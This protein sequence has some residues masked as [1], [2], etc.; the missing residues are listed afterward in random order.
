MLLKY[1]YN[2]A[3]AQASYLIGCQACAEAI[4]IDPGRDIAPYLEMAEREGLHIAHVTETHIH[5]DFVSGAR[6]LAAASGAQ[7]YLSAEGGA[8]WQ[9][10]YADANTILL[11]D[12]DIISVGRVLIQAIHTPGH[13]PEHLIFSWT[14]TAGADQP[15]GLIT[16]DCLFVGD[17]GRPDLL[18]TAAGIMGTKEVG[19]RDQF[20]NIQK[21][22]AMPDY[23]QILPGHGAGSACG[24]ALGAIPSSTLGYEKLFNPAFQFTDEDAFV[25]WLLDGQLETPH[26]FARMKRM[27]KQGPA[28][29]ETLPAPERVEGFVVAQAAHHGWVIDARPAEQ[30]AAGHL[31]GA[32][33]IP[34]GSGF[35]GY[36]GW[37]IPDDQPV[38]LITDE[39]AV[40]E[41][42]TALRSVGVDH[43][44]G[45]CAP[46]DIGDDL[47]MVAQT[48]PREAKRLLDDDSAL[49]LDVRGASERH[50][51]QIAGSRHLHY[52]YLMAHVS[53]LPRDT[54]IIVQCAGGTRSM[55]AAS[56]LQ[57]AG[58]RQVVNLRGGID[59]W[60]N[61][62]L[63]VQTG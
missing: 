26:Y 10:A 3:L 32:L 54:P 60:Q 4:V 31:P 11:R 22:R 5:A 39:D 55:I 33:H 7:L 43:V 17:V 42:V 27:N 48:D 37:L 18:E 62:G 16:G 46:S 25:A 41:L 24:K 34:P 59:A 44:A 8:D 49:L 21:L 56:I 63:P 51:A 50:E 35:A 57:R 6:Q 12:Q 2:P 61:A 38:Y 30:F 13:T 40:P 53:D 28:L 9:Y 47:V 58:L 45:W 20:R 29:L 14:D 1:F 36:A 19:A 15:M 23:L 52:G